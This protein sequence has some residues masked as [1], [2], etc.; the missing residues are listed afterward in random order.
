MLSGE[1][2]GVVNSVAMDG[3]L[4][5]G[6]DVGAASAIT[7]VAVAEGICIGNHSSNWRGN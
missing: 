2:S 5:K 4:D 7:V 3:V 1:T 6:A